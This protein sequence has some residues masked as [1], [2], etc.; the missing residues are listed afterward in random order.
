MSVELFLLIK[1]NVVVLDY[2]DYDKLTHHGII[3]EQK[4]KIDQNGYPYTYVYRKP[5]FLTYFVLDVIPKVGY[6]IHHKDENKLNAKKLNLEHITWSSH[7]RIHHATRPFGVGHMQR[8]RGFIAFIQVEGKRKHLGTFKT[9]ELAALIR[10]RS[11]FNHFKDIE[12]L[13]YPTLT[14]EQRQH[15]IEALL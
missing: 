10:D 1:G 6:L 3:R 13:N 8:G 5:I 15:Q 14:P 12:H 4:W 2:E 9:I 11:F 7:N